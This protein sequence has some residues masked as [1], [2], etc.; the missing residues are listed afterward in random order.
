MMTNR[1][2]RHRAGWTAAL[3]VAGLIAPAALLA[4]P[5]P[6]PLGIAGVRAAM[7]GRADP[8]SAAPAATASALVQDPDTIPNFTYEVAV[9]EKKPEL[10]NKG[11]VA[12]MLNRYY[13]RILH[14]AGIGGQVIMQFV[15]TPDGTVDPA[16]VKVIRASHQQFGEASAM[17]VKTFRFNPGIH[18]G[19]PVR[20]LLQ[21]PITW[22]P[23]V[24]ATPRPDS[25]RGP[26]EFRRI[27][28]VSPRRPEPAAGA[29]STKFTYEVAVLQ[30]K[31]ELLNRAEVRTLVDRVYPRE[32][33]DAGVSGNALMQFVIASNGTVDPSTIKVVSVSDPRF[34]TPGRLVAEKLTFEPGLYKSN[35]IRTLIQM[36]IS[37]Q[38]TTETKPG[39][40]IPEPTPVN[41]AA[42]APPRVE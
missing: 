15:I 32:L 9:L 26:E 17:V 42:P 29:D 41:P 31:P 2:I 21:M 19:K 3:A 14:D 11:E 4:L 25:A 39:V 18:K 40:D 23:D 38:P 20:V 30:R 27:G 1:Q 12:S 13:P 5:A 16:S 7:A 34:A 6:A 37:W 8:E 33:K 24:P 35:A 28:S 22:Q 10:T 36:P